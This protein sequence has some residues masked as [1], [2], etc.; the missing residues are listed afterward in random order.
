MNITLAGRSMRAALLL[1]LV[2]GW[3]PAALAQP[4]TDTN[5]VVKAGTQEHPGKTTEDLAKLRKEAL[6]RIEGPPVEGSGSAGAQPKSHLP[7]LVG[8]SAALL[9]LLGMAI[10]ASWRRLATRG[11]S[12]PGAGHE[13][14]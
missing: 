8:I 4:E 1:G 2:P 14:S 7:E 13:G 12:R 11:R 9:F 3:G 5:P 6:L 10:L